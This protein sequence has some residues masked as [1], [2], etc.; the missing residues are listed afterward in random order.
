MKSLQGK[1][2]ST[3]MT[4][5]VVVEVV[6]KFRHPLYQKTVSRH[7]KYKASITADQQITEGDEVMI[8]ESRPIA[9][10]VNFV[11]TKIV[12]KLVQ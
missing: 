2:V 7:K 11:V 6:R 10:S 8:R 3:K 12:K 4:G 9:K 5:T 1:V